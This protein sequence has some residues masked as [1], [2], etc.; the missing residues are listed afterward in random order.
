M[1]KK[2]LIPTTALALFMSMSSAFAEESAP[3]V[4]DMPLDQGIVIDASADETGAVANTST[5][6][7]DVN[8]Q[9]TQQAEEEAAA[10]DGTTLPLDQGDINATE[11]DKG[12][13][14]A[15][16]ETNQPEVAPEQDTVVLTENEPVVEPLAQTGIASNGLAYAGLAGVLGAV[17]FFVSRRYKTADQEN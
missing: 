7:V 2:L 12:S 6:G 10:N 3:P 13:K 9:V 1:K 11:I 16:V 5:E 17:G 14:E 15:E 8:A 4:S